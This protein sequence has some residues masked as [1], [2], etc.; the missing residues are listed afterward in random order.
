MKKYSWIVAVLLAL[1][2][3][4]IGC[5]DK[6]DPIDPGDKQPV[7]SLGAFNVSMN[8]NFQ[9]GEGY[10]GLLDNMKLFPGGKITKGDVY[11]MK[12]TFT[13]SRDLEDVITVGLVD[14]TDPAGGGDYWIPLSYD[15]DD[16]GWDFDD[17]DAPAILATVDE[18]A[19]G[20]EVTKVITF[21]ALKTA[22]TSQANANSIAFETQG[23]G[24]K[25]T[26][27]SGVKKPFQLRVTEFLFVKG[28]AEDLEGGD[29]EPPPEG[30][31]PNPV[32]ADEDYTVK[33]EGLTMKNAEPTTANYANLW[34]DLS[35]AFPATFDIS[36]YNAFTVKAK[37]YDADG[38]E[39]TLA[40]GLGQIN[41]TTGNNP[42]GGSGVWLIATN[43]GNLGMAGT[44]EVALLEGA[45]FFDQTPKF[46]Y[47]QNTNANVKF[48]EITEITFHWGTREAAPAGPPDP[49]AET[50]PTGMI[51]AFRITL[52][53]KGDYDNLWNWDDSGT[54]YL[55]GRIKAEKAT[56]ILALT[57][58]KFQIYWISGAG[59]EVAANGIGAFGGVGYN[60]P[61][62]TT[63]GMFEGNISELNTLTE[64]AGQE[65]TL[66]L[67]TY[68]GGDVV[69]IIF[70][71]PE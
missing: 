33:L 25:E 8:D 64:P 36:K 15:E 2:L 71:E 65:G 14:R 52:E 68:N 37:F 55:K 59:T 17:D 69:K 35:E 27:N 43:V 54:A 30:Y 48:I 38:E 5:P 45:G 11:T 39:I 1:S 63:A 70:Y 67:N 7:I 23:E 58:G 4:L 49:V 31:V 6:D 9:Y 46:L 28:T 18:A 40:N 66:F 51:E 20:A 16:G 44:E 61:G 34:F 12:I 32:V 42:W 21:T 26:A 60:S 53:D 47:A 57:G 50:I 29:V 19:N 22:L 24:I 56:E 10:Q 41:F 3:G 13:T 62:G